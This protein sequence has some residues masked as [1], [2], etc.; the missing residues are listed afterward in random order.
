M[1]R[2]RCSEERERKRR[3]RVEAREYAHARARALRRVLAA[4]AFCERDDDDVVVEQRGDWRGEGPLLSQIATQHTKN[5]L[6]RGCGREQG[7]GCK[8]GEREQKTQH[9]KQNCKEDERKDRGFFL[10][11][12]QLPS[13]VSQRNTAPPGAAERAGRFPQLLRA[14]KRAHTERGERQHQRQHMTPKKPPA[15][16]ERERDAPP[17]P[18]LGLT[19]SRPRQ[20]ARASSRAS[21]HIVTA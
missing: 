15:A 17:P 9:K 7:G 4:A 2:Q 19:A 20:P 10:C 1:R 6:H 11:S 21:N 14:A 8:K 13:R 5:T 18:P 16:R 12:Q 3:E